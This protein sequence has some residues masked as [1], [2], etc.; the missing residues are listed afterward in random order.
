MP[1]AAKPKKVGKIMKKTPSLVSD[2][3]GK[4]MMPGKMGRNLPMIAQQNP[5]ASS[6][7]SKALSSG[8]K[9]GGRVRGYA[10]AG[11]VDWERDEN[12]EAQ[13]VERKSFSPGVSGSKDYLKEAPVRKAAPKASKAEPKEEAKPVRVSRSAPE[14]DS[15]DG[16][17]VRN[18][19]KVA[20]GLGL[21]AA[22]MAAI[23]SRG[24][25]I[26][27]SIRALRNAPAYTEAKNI[28][29]MAPSFSQKEG[30]SR[31]VKSIAKKDEQAK[32]DAVSR[33]NEAKAK[34]ADNLA[35]YEEGRTPQAQAKWLRENPNDVNAKRM[36]TSQSRSMSKDARDM[37][38]GSEMGYKKGGKVAKP[39]PT[40]YDRMQ[41]SR[42]QQHENEP[43]GMAHKAVRKA[44]GGIL[45]KG[46]KER[47]ASKSAMKKHEAKETKAEEKAEHKKRGGFAKRSFSRR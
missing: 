12:P 13:E 21:G 22:A 5:Y 4:A 14:E 30:A 37:D 28:S 6:P 8:Y 43:M 26:P 1:K 25:S 40:A 19:A 45:E 29:K 34:S 2:R 17:G 35:R 31:A 38:V 24:K 15:S 18:A 39:K 27:A 47:Y 33:A 16:E 23:M 3:R 7:M 44:K 10:E 46:S 42:L 36:V 20:G 9:K 41:D 32:L 11:E